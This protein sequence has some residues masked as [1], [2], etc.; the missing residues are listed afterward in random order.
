MW[1][2]RLSDQPCWRMNVIDGVGVCGGNPRV[3][4]GET[5]LG[6]PHA[7]QLCAPMVVV[8]T[9]ADLPMASCR[10]GCVTLILI[11]HPSQIVT[12]RIGQTRAR[13]TELY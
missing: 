12:A 8:L 1:M 5:L 2:P 7:V 9:V 6:M 3:W 13:W 10:T 4:R 11:R